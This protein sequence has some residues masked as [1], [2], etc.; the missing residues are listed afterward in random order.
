MVVNDALN[1]Q[2]AMEVNIDGTHVKEKDVEQ[3]PYIRS[4]LNQHL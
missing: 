4:T 2:A 3:V 1:L